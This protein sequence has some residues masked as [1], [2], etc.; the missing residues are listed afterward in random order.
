MING[1]GTS[2]CFNTR[3][4]V[5]SNGFP[6][7]INCDGP[8]VMRKRSVDD[9]K[10]GCILTDVRRVCCGGDVASEGGDV[11]DEGEVISESSEMGEPTAELSPK[12]M[13]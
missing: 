1:L 9:G 5:T 4:S 12:Q 3:L 13:M 2:N 7:E 11:G 10:R 8:D 6:V